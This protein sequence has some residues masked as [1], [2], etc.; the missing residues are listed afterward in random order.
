MKRTIATPLLFLFLIAGGASAS[1]HEFVAST[2][3]KTTIKVLRSTVFTSAAG[4]S[5][6]AGASL[7][8]GEVTTTKSATIT[9]TIK[10]ENCKAFGLL[11][12]VSPVNVRSTAE[13][14]VSL[15]KTVTV[16]V[17]ACQVTFPSAKNQNLFTIKY[18]NTNKQIEKVAE[19]KHVDSSGTGAA[20]TYAEESNGTLSGDA[21]V[22]LIGGGTLEWK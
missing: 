7:L 4:T 2:T 17:T 15:L 6:C 11:A 16:K 1:A 9:S 8:A 10:F 3:G 20:C 22:G 19:L 12:T 5:E 21:L 14:G 13:G 18:K